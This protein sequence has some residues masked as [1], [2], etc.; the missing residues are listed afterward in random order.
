MNSPVN[1]LPRTPRPRRVRA[2]PYLMPRI[3]HPYRAGRFRR[4]RGGY[5][6]GWQP[7]AGP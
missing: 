1:G 3:S 5:A 7:R 2:L 4:D 6:D